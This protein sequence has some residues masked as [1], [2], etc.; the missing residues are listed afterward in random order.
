[1]NTDAL[2]YRLFATSPETLFLALG[3]SPQEAEATAAQYQFLAV[4]FKETAHR[5]DGVF[6]PKEPG[7]PLYFIEAQFYPLPKVY[8]DILAKAYTY[9]KQNDPRQSFRAVVLFGRRSFEPEVL[10][11]YQPLLDADY[12]RR[13]FVS[14]LPEQPAAPLGLSILRLIGRPPEP[15]TQEA[16]ELV[17]RAKSEIGDASLQHELVDLI[18]TVVICKLPQFTREEIQA[19]LE[20]SDI[21]ETKVYQEALEEGLEKGMEK[22]LEKGRDEGIAQER[23]RLLEAIPGLAQR[24]LS[25]SDIAESLKLD[26]A[27][28]QKALGQ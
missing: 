23:A 22:G 6:Q 13:I 27:V 5:A 7:L 2:F 19:M 3:M 28:V 24:G 9:L 15:A 26:L 17:K 8:A 1:M 21:R 14:E 11:P 10:T 18:E 16:K 20:V 12:L 25:A 4:E